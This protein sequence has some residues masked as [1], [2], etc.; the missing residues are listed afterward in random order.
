[1][2]SNDMIRQNNHDFI[3][4]LQS[5]LSDIS[6]I[7]LNHPYILAL[8]K[9]EIRRDKL[10]LF[11]SEQYHIIR[12]DRRNFALMISKASNDIATKL[13]LDCLSVEVEAL[14]TLFIM[15]RELGV[16]I[17]KLESYEPMAGSNAYTNYLTRLAVYGS[18]AEIL[19]TVL[20]DFPIW[21][22]NCGKMS[23]AL[24]RNYG[25]DDSSCRFL[26]KFAVPLPED[27][28]N[29]SNELIKSALPVYEK[30]MTRAARL[31]LEYE[32]SF[33]NTIHKYSM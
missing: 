17:N 3:R 7:I 1:M 23:S 33:W 16:S 26:D 13:F 24:K 15:T 25:Y 12:N 8:D 18:D 20:V 6:A 27:F 19:T 11:V 30:E 10:E 32:L 21:G 22:A 28:V 2:S 9:N 14:D 29:K 5:S 31:I 4:N